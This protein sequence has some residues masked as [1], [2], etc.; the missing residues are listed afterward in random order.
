MIWKLK[1]ESMDKQCFLVPVC[2]E[3]LLYNGNES[4]KGLSVERED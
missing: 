4:R 1:Q 2:F 3:S